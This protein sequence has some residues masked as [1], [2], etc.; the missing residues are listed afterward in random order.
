MALPTVWVRA[1]LVR[2]RA[3]YHHACLARSDSLLRNNQITQYDFVTQQKSKAEG[4]HAAREALRY[5]KLVESGKI[6]RVDYV[7]RPYAKP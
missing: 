4:L 7:T 3:R 5:R 1:S 2:K 6:D